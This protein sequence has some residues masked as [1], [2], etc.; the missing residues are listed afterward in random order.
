MFKPNKYQEAIYKEIESGTG[1]IAINAV[2]G[3][4]KTTTLVQAYQLL[5]RNK[6]VLFLAFNK[7]IAESLAA[8]LPGADCRTIHSLGNMTLRSYDKIT[9]SE[10]KMADLADEVLASIAIKSRDDYKA[11]VGI[12]R[13]V[14]GMAKL[15]LTDL[16]DKDAAFAMMEHYSMLDE[17][18]AI[19]G[20]TEEFIL[21]KA[22]V[23]LARSNAL[24]RQK[25]VVDF[26]DMLYIPCRFD[27]PVKQYDIV[28]VDEAQDLSNAQ[29]GLV[30]R[31]AQHGRII[32]V[33]D[34]RQAINGFAGANNDSF[35][36][37][38]DKTNAKTLPLSVCYRCP[39]S[40]ITLAQR[41]V[42]EIEWHDN[43]ADGI[44]SEITEDQ[45]TGMAH[46]G[47]LIIC[48][49]NAPLIGVA[50]RLI[51]GGI[52]AR[53]RGRNIAEGL[54]KLAKDASKIKLEYAQAFKVDFPQQLS[55]LVE[56]KAETLSKQK[57]KEAAIEA[58]F[59]RQQCILSFMEAKPDLTSIEQL[60]DELSKLFADDKA[61]VW[62]SSIHRAKGLEANRVFVLNPRKMMFEG[63]TGWQLDQEYNLKYVGLTRAKEALYFVY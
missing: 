32:A 39:R 34:P 28:M 23:V 11:I 18:Y 38:V 8:K 17:I 61:A 37:I 15:T 58:L 63:A 49:V 59:D 20:L 16:N 13:D 51:S 36:Q 48:R 45:L 42:P 56:H 21:D 53:V 43:A 47:D 46:S 40:H 10:Y 33:G 9:M 6:S 19:K 2:A 55:L 25:G 52:Q 29:L 22:S 54:A 41:I 5:P 60:C 7:H 35:Q 1:N 4:G 44:I 3:S 14:V 31:A 12:V 30:L 26:N 62:L 27:L 24:W 57:N 50:L